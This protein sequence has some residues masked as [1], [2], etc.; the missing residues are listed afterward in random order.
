MYLLINQS[1]LD[2]KWL[3][4]HH[5][6][7]S[8]FF[9]IFF[10]VCIALSIYR[11]NIYMSDFNMFTDPAIDAKFFGKNP[12][13]YWNNNSYS[14]FFYA[15]ITP[16]TCFSKWFAVLVWSCLSIIGLLIIYGVAINALHDKIALKKTI[17]AFSIMSFCLVDNFQL[18]QS[19]VLMLSMIMLGF[20]YYQKSKNVYAS[21][22]I[23][24]AIAF[25][26]IPLFLVFYFLVKKEFKI[27]FWSVFIAVGLTVFVPLII[28]PFNDFNI[29]IV[30]WFEGVF[31]PFFSGNEFATTTASYY[32]TNQ[33]FEAFLGRLL[34]KFDE[35]NERAYVNIETFN[36][37]VKSIKLTFLGALILI[38]YTSKSL[39]KRES[40]T[41]F[42]L[43]IYGIIFISPVAWVNYYILL[44]PLVFAYLSI[45]S[46]TKILNKI[47]FVIGVILLLIDVD[48]ILQKFSLHFIG[49]FLMFAC[50]YA[51]LLKMKHKHS[52]K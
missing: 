39:T 22:W 9:V 21:F 31:Y 49:G 46:R 20:Y 41:E 33:S 14:P 43:W 35:S 29:Y 25:K 15:V 2:F 23:G 42:S 12:I 18:G 47:V 11:V 38:S 5:S 26:I 27:A 36:Y 1:I 19:N 34:I 6:R 3:H 45:S 50:T 52:P 17:I 24:F 40:Y 44:F 30:S 16:L 37:L 4:K 7:L 10:I 13:T 32:H 51:A 48:P 8:Y 28:Y